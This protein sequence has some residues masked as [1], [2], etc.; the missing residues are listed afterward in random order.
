MLPK[1]PRATKF[2]SKQTSWGD[3]ESALIWHT[4][5]SDGIHAVVTFGTPQTA[6]GRDR[7][8]WAAAVREDIIALRQR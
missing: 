7:R 3:T 5:C 1:E 6:D 8:T 2:V 4:L